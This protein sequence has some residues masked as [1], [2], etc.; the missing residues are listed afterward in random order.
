MRASNYVIYSKP[1]CPHCV[2]AKQF[3]TFY[4]VSFVERDIT[5][6]IDALRVMKLH[7]LGTVPQVFKDGHLI[8]DSQEFIKH[9]TE[10]RYTIVTEDDEV[11]ERGLTMEEAELA[12]CRHINL[13]A[14][15]SYIGDDE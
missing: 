2:K 1:A 15:D 5:Q 12:L 13:G 7:E 10:K 6:D 8:G 11:L 3:A 9:L 4:G 14:E